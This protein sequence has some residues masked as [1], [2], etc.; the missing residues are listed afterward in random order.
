MVLLDIKM[1]GVDGFEVLRWIRAHPEFSYLLIVML[2]SSEAIADA[3]TAYRLGAASFF[4]K[5]FD[6]GDAEELSRTIKRLMAR[7]AA[8]PKPPPIPPATLL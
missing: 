1:P 2:T 5:P 7:P 6:F 8:R 3:D 4:V